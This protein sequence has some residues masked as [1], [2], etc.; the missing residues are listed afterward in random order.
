M[1]LKTLNNDNTALSQSVAC[2]EQEQWSNNRHPWVRKLSCC[3]AN[4]G[5][6]KVSAQA[7]GTTNDAVETTREVS[8]AKTSQ[9]LPYVKSVLS[10]TQSEKS[11]TGKSDWQQFY[12]AGKS[13]INTY[14]GQNSDIGWILCTA[15]LRCEKKNSS[16]SNSR[17]KHSSI[18]VNDFNRWS[19]S[20][21]SR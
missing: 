18:I 17:R 4:E 10:T 8:A 7:T 11:S 20:P 19:N 16:N 15:G 5:T 14:W 1:Q 12:T 21:H 13:D 9:Q 3:P 6:A 2:N